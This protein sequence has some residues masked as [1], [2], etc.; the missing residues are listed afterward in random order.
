VIDNGKEY[1]ASHA[2]SP[3]FLTTSFLLQAYYYAQDL[4]YADSEVPTASLKAKTF[5][6]LKEHYSLKLSVQSS[7]SRH[8]IGQLRASLACPRTTTTSYL[9]FL[10]NSEHS[11]SLLIFFFVCF[12]VWQLAV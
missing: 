12:P 3:P 7:G 11:T 4:T 8:L 6:D 5:Q 1:K 9:S 10:L 2:L